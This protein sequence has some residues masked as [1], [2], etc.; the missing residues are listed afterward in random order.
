MVQRIIPLVMCGGSGTRLWPASR[1]GW[2]KQFLPL[3]GER[4]TF[5]DT[6]RRVSDPEVFERRGSNGVMVQE[7][8]V[9]EKALFYY[10]LAKTY[11]KAG[12][13]ERML[14]YVR[15]ALENGFKE[16][17]KF[18]EDFAVEIRPCENINSNSGSGSSPINPLSE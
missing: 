11:A 3:F 2:P 17:N 12:D 10:T 14:R 1:E 8:S 15:F 16:R 4:S 13:A 5:Q 7:R 18:L 6:L 9:E